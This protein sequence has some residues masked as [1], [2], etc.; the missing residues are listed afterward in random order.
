MCTKTQLLPQQTW[1]SRSI[2]PAFF[3][4]VATSLLFAGRAM[5]WP[6]LDLK[7]DSCN[8]EQVAV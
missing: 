5:R 4:S 2:C 7:N 3:R 6:D 8:M 1:K